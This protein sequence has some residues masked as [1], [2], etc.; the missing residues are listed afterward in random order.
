VAE[1]ITLSTATWYQNGA[2][3]SRTP[4]RI[5]HYYNNNV[6]YTDVLRYQFTTTSAASKIT[7]T[8]GSLQLDK[9]NFANADKTPNGRIKFFITEDTSNSYKNARYDEALS[10]EKNTYKYDG[11]LTLDN[12]TG[13]PATGT[14]SAVKA[15]KPNTTYYLYLFPSTPSNGFKFL[16]YVNNAGITINLDGTVIQI[17]EGEQSLAVAPM[18]KIN[19]ELKPVELNLHI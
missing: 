12:P 14:G 19:G 13:S 4:Q 11:T 8:K 1:A 17:K 18:I 6:L 3:T 2:S 7:V 16:Y 5:G 15:L 9:D 10:E